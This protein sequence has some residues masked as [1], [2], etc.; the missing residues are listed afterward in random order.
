MA[1]II[2]LIILGVVLLLPVLTKTKHRDWID[3]RRWKSVLIFCLKWLL[4]K[5]GDVPGKLSVQE[6]EQY[7]IRTIS[8]KGCLKTASGKCLSG[9]GCN[10]LARMNVRVDSCSL[11]RWGPFLSDKK[12]DEYKEKYNIRFEAYLGNTNID[13]IET[14]GYN[15]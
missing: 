6:I 4:H 1:V 11:G 9:C 10:T 14:E 15:I 12:W 3:P 7:M 13:N 2:L 5:L 8:C